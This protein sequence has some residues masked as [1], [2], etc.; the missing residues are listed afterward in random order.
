VTGSDIQLG[1]V[2]I[3]DGG[4]DT[5]ATI[6]ADNAAGSTP[7]ALVTGTQYNSSAPTYA[8]GDIA[9][10]QS[11]VN[12]NLK[13]TLAT[14]IAGEDLTNDVM[15]VEEQFSYAYIAS[16]TTTQVKSG[17]TFLKAIVV[18]TTAAGTIGIIDNTSGSTVNVGQLKASVVEGTY[19]YNIRLSAGLRIVTGAASDITVVYR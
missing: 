6:L 19:E 17:A 14:K 9:A 15:K 11:D 13:S 3:K 7:N 5:R 12:G 8:S 10:L 4:S 1:A 18:N 16:A 2:E